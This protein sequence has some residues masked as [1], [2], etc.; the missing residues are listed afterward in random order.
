[1]NDDVPSLPA[2]WATDLDILRLSGASIE[3]HDDHLVVRSQANPWAHWGNFVMV[4]DPA[5]DAEADRWV[6]AFGREFP[7]ASWLAVGLTTTPPATSWQRH[8]IE[9]E[10]LDVLATRTAPRTTDAVP[11]YEIRPFT[12]ADWERDIVRAIAEN[13]ATGAYDAAEY[14]AFVT[15]QADVRRGLTERGDAAWFGAFAGER[16]VADLGIVRCGHRARYQDVTTDPGHRR[17]GLAGHLLGVAGQ[18]AAARGC[19]EWVIVT[20]PANDAGRVYRAAGFLPVAGGSE[21]YRRP[22]V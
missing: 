16:L 8:G 19:T 12:A 1:M 5:A 2:N 6:S 20:E 9:I 11:G 15:R 14:G 10:T 13:E 22:P 7:D 17:R 3:T 4:T 18:W 21:A